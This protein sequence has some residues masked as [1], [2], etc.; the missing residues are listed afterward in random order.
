MARMPEFCHR[1]GERFQ[2]VCM[3]VPSESLRILL[4]RPGHSHIKSARGERGPRNDIRFNR[5]SAGICMGMLP[6]SAR[7][8]QDA[9]SYWR[10]RKLL[11][12]WRR[13][14]K[15]VVQRFGCRRSSLAA[16]DDILCPDR[17]T[18]QRF[19]SIIVA[20]HR[21]TLEGHAGKQSLRA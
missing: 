18:V 7:R 3:R 5:V 17:F 4:T 14:G 15:H 19:V 16:L 2:T 6:P 20:V 1:G 9:V 12:S 8:L 11:A 10:L 13:L 21:R